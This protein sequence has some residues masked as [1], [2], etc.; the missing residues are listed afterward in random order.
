MT[1]KLAFLTSCMLSCNA[2]CAQ[3]T[4]KLITSWMF[5]TTNQTYNGS[6]VNVEAVY[7]TSSYVYVKSTG[8][9]SNYSST[10]TVHNGGSYAWSASA[11]T[12]VFILP[13]SSTQSIPANDAAR[14]YLRDE[15]NV[16]VFLNGS[17][18]FSPGDGKTYTSGGVSG[19]W[20][21]LAYQFEYGDMDSYNGHSNPSGV[22]HYHA[23]P[24]S[25][26]SYAASTT[27]S[28]IIGFAFDGYP[29]YG[30]YGYTTA[31]SSS[32]AI[33]RMKTSWVKSTYS[34][35]S[36]MADGTTPSQTGPTYA[37]QALGKYWEDYKY[38]SGYGDL[39]RYNGRTC[40]TPE[41]PSGT[42]AYFLTFDASGNPEFP[43]IIGDYLYGQP[44]MTNNGA[45]MVNSSTRV[46]SNTIPANAVL[47]VE[48]LGF[49]AKVE[50]CT[51]LLNWESASETKFDHYE[52]EFSADN[53]KSFQ[54]IAAIPA[55]GSAQKYDFRH[56]SPNLISY[57]R[58]KMVDKDGSFQ[59]SPVVSANVP[60]NLEQIG[61]DIFPN[62]FLE[63]L[64]IQL[65]NNQLHKVN[66]Y[67]SS[68]QILQTLEMTEF[69][70][71]DLSKQPSGT[72]IIEVVDPQ[73]KS[74]F[75]KKVVKP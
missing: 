38:T 11:K 43:Y 4:D 58:L 19:V 21:Q 12:N 49:N 45:F 10:N 33:T 54:K 46:T 75:M 15:G 6:L 22:Y 48:L 64:S 37:S 53:A 16:A 60:C 74:G 71:I 67:N 9:P 51:V 32:S 47:P 55:K 24:S 8:I 5:N 50:D 20:H 52:V 66:I 13:R 1:R 31:M 18:A 70:K 27:H 42:Y 23:N 61:I 57:Y 40:V 30:P 68:G 41:Y 35:R 73:T 3:E 34:D 62:P 59:Y 29:I 28:P 69:V 65:N 2:L 36:T 56:H 44:I 17:V 14:K 39:D 26:F 7:Y 72:Y 25:L 63:S